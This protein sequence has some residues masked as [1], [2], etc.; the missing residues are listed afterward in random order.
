LASAC[1]IPV[2]AEEQT[3]QL[4]AIGPDGPSSFHTQ[5][6]VQV[7]NESFTS[8]PLLEKLKVSE[9]LIDG[10]SFKR[11]E[12]PFD[13]PVGLSAQGSWQG[14]L[15]V[16]EYAPGGISPG[17][18]RLQW[19][20]GKGFSEE[21]HAKFYKPVP[22]ATTAKER[23]HQVTALKEALAPG[24]L[25]SCVENWLTERD[26]GLDNLHAV[27]YYVDPDV[28][29][30]VPYDQAVPEPHIKGPVRIYVE[31]RVAD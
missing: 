31:S 2:L 15:S 4:A 20:L 22:V 18:H 8:F 10:H 26:G 30:H 13:G 25:K 1:V 3:L 16:E 14:C 27:R 19:R 5:L 12:A 9:L 24:L 28:K 6:Q 7:T 23:L 21:I 29:V 11:Q 17:R